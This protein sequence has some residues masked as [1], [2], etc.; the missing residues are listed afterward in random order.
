M[1]L[2]ITDTSPVNYL[3]QIG[4][5]DVLE[6][7]FGRVIMPAAVLSELRHSRAPAAVARWVATMPAWIE[8]VRAEKLGEG[9]EL[10]PGESEAIAI[11]LENVPSLL[12]V[13]DRE[14]R[15]TARSLG[16]RV[17]GTV[18]IL[19]LAAESRLL[20]FESAVAALLATNFHIRA[21]VIEHSRRNLKRRGLLDH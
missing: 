9:F 10:G 7:L 18:N 12:L 17:L 16:L 3:V 20:S 14:A 6:K 8:V 13:D 19:E 21:E 11:A 5:I 15:E 2:V 1:S 4:Q